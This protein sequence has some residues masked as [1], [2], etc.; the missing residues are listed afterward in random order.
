MEIQFYYI[1]QFPVKHIKVW[2][3]FQFIIE[4]THLCHKESKEILYDNKIGKNYNTIE[5]HM[6]TSLKSHQ[7]YNADQSISLQYNY[8]NVK[9]KC[10]KLQ[11]NINVPMNIEWYFI[12]YFLSNK[13]IFW[14]IDRQLITWLHDYQNVFHLFTLSP[15]NVLFSQHN[16]PLK[17]ANKGITNNNF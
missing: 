14:I 13:P 17:Y 16:L 11:Y 15:S 3:E 8:L 6:C 5:V 10:F 4:I 7:N 12:I 2:C 1:I 9:R